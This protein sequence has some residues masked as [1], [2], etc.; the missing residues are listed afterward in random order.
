MRKVLVNY[1]VELNSHIYFKHSLFSLM[2]GD[3]AP[4]EY[5]IEIIDY[6]GGLIKKYSNENLNVERCYEGNSFFYVPDD[7]ALEDIPNY[8]ASGDC[9]VIFNDDFSSLC[10]IKDYLIYFGQIS[11]T[12][13]IVRKDLTPFALD[14]DVFKEV[15][16]PFVNA[17]LN[18]NN[19]IGMNAEIISAAKSADGKV[20]KIVT[21]GLMVD[22]SLDANNSNLNRILPS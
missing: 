15:L 10:T 12:L 18:I 7:I 1:R 5:D 13:Y 20:Y 8:I 19:I 16:T 3:Y 17:Y 21:K 2:D 9:T 4:E 11:G 6:E 14:F 22:K